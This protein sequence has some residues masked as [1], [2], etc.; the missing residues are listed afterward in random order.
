MR[1]IT[2]EKRW[3]VNSTVGIGYIVVPFGVDRDRFVKSCYR[4]QR[5]HIALDFGGTMYKN[6][7]IDPRILQE[8]KFPE[9][10]KKLGSQIVYVMDKFNAV[11]I[12]V[13]SL[14]RADERVVSGEESF[15]IHRSIDGGDL[16]LKGNGNGKLFLNISSINGAKVKIDISGENSSLEVNNEGSTTLYSESDININSS[17]KVTQNFLNSSGKIDKTLKLD[18]TGLEFTD[19]NE[20]KFFIDFENGTINHHEGLEPIPLGNKLQKELNNLKEKFNMFLDT[21][22]NT[23]AVPSDGGKTIQTAVK[24]ATEF[25]E[26][27]DFDDINSE[28]SFID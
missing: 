10:S 5:V 27:A 3:G 4:K 11:P 21:F 24:I 14:E 16:Y 17:G 28:K 8:I 25:K 19:I 26:D 6:C 15:T 23:P 22:V 12:I 7:Y 9:E 20:N 1:G 2:R 18:K 13:A